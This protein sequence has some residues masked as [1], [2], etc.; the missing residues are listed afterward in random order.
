MRVVLLSTFDLGRQPFG[1]ASPAAWLKRAGF[2]VR[3]VDL[4]RDKLSPDVM[5]GAGLAAFYLPMHTATRLALPVI[6]RLRAIDPSLTIA[7][8]GLYAPLNEALLRERGVSIVLGPESEQELVEAV[9][10]SG[11][12]GALGALGANPLPRLAFIPPDRTGL[13]P[14][15]RYASLQMPDG[16]SKVVGAT[17]ATRGCKH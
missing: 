17:D 1:L 11:A 12:S 16:S 14:L 5:T 6:A 8:Y 13:P 4:S 15:D 10:A 9:G 3:C 2:E 7:A